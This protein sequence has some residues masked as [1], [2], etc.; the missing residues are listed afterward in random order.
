MSLGN[1]TRAKAGD[2]EESG[3]GSS[4]GTI[5]GGFEKSREA[6]STQISPQGGQ[7]RQG[8]VTVG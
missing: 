7:Q 8:T 2:L 3:L 5:T 6:Q 1:S 4:Q